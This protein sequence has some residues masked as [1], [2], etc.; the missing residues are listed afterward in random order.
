M[1]PSEIIYCEGHPRE[2]RYNESL[3]SFTK[4][5][6]VLWENEAEVGSSLVFQPIAWRV[7]RADLN[8]Q[9]ADWFEIFFVDDENHLSTILLTGQTYDNLFKV[10]EGML[11]AGC[12]FEA[13]T[14]SIKVN[15]N[16][17]DFLHFDFREVGPTAELQQYAQQTKIYNAATSVEVISL[18]ASR[19]YFPI[20]KPE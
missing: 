6:Y 14:V 13:C 2:Y 7:F 18:K 12:A 16:D 9:V 8:G 17:V 11:F 1:N 20:T 5:D 19:N 4:T 3:Q 10:L 15:E